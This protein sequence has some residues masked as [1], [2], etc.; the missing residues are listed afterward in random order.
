[1][2][3]KELF[4]GFSPEEQERQEQYLI[5]RWGDGA[6]Q[7]IAQAKERVKDWT[8]ADWEKSGAAFNAIC[9]EVVVLME[10][11]LSSGSREVQDVIRRHYEWLKQFWTPNRESYS[12]HSQTIVD[13]DLRKPYEAHH[14][15]LPA[16][17]AAAMRIFA[18]NQ[19][20]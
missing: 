8:K 18:E 12:G 9:Q 13:S 15:E 19:L 7:G 17:M 10:R 6:R 1:M 14:P 20:S 16:F 4:A 11:K 2:K 3:S 5:D